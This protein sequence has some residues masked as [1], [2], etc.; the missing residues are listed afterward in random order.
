[1]NVVLLL[2]YF[3]FHYVRIYRGPLACLFVCLCV[4]LFTCLSP[5]LTLKTGLEKGLEMWRKKVSMPSI[6]RNKQYQDGNKMCE[7]SSACDRI[8]SNMKVCLLSPSKIIRVKICVEGLIGFKRIFLVGNIHVTTQS[9]TWI[10][11]CRR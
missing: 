5:K 11:R 2:L 6:Y 9:S 7:K 8:D 3:V 10:A 1:M 4:C